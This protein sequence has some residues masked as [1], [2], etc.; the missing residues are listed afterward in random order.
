M[1]ALINAVF[2]SSEVIRSFLKT[3]ILAYDIANMQVVLRTLLQVPIVGVYSI[4]PIQRLSTHHKVNFNDHNIFNKIRILYCVPCAHMYI[5]AGRAVP[6]RGIF[7]DIKWVVA[8]GWSYDKTEEISS[9]FSWSTN[10]L[11]KMSRSNH[12]VCRADETERK[13][14]ILTY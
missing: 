6:K 5:D 9:L 13:G 4:I 11:I 10:V 7:S 12:V 2:V 14:Q 8:F 1:H 3:W